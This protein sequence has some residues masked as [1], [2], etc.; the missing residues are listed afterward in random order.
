MNALEAGAAYAQGMADGS[1]VVE[2]T[3]HSMKFHFATASG[4][5]ELSSPLSAIVLPEK[6]INAD[7]CPIYTIQTLI[8]SGSELSGTG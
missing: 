2:L 6:H 3:G 4:D 1:D 7:S 5:R 8:Q